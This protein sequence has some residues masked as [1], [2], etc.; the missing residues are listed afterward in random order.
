MSFHPRRSLALFAVCGGWLFLVFLGSAA[1]WRY[2]QTP[3]DDPVA[4]LGWPAASTIQRAID[5]PTL[6]LFMHPRCACSRAT[7]RELERLLAHSQ[8]R[9]STQVLMF[10]PPGSAPSWAMGDLWRTAAAIPGVVV[11]EDEGGAEA[12]LFHGETSGH[13]VLYDLSG[14]LIFDGGITSSRGHEG[15]NA[16]LTALMAFVQKET[17]QQRHTQ[18]FG[19]RIRNRNDD[20]NCGEK[21]CAR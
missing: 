13:A 16:G 3:G 21:P 9:L 4:P 20:T 11:H 1:L 7:L 6:I 19:C 5:R 8:D 18:I 15:D 12:R 10:R 14:Q 17:P 2:K